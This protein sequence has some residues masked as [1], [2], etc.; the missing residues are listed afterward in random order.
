MKFT[1][2]VLSLLLAQCCFAFE[3]DSLQRPAVKGVVK[4]SGT[5]T[6]LKAGR[7]F[8]WESF[9][10]NVVKLDSTQLVNGQFSFNEREV[11]LGIYM[12]GMNENNMCP[13]ILNPSEKNIELQFASA[14]LEASM[15]SE[16][17]KENQGWGFYIQQEP[18]LLKAIK[19]AKVGAAKNPEKKAEFDAQLSA[20]EADLLNLQ[21]KTIKLYPG[22]Q[23]AKLMQ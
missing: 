19:D 23:M 20:R 21:N 4:V 18:A 22:T 14:K 9:G 2:C 10:R 3:S 11:E 7:I 12:L 17:S 1:L 15:S 13:I 8:L 16:T 5:I 6:G